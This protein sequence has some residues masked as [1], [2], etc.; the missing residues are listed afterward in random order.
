MNCEYGWCHSVFGGFIT[1]ALPITVGF[2]LGSEV[3]LGRLVW[4]VVNEYCSEATTTQACL[5]YV[6]LGHCRV[7]RYTWC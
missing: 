7:A 5:G 1:P 3:F 4:F 2:E 6:T